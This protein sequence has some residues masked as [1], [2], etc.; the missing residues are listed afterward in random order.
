MLSRSRLTLFTVRAIGLAATAGILASCD[1]EPQ[2]VTMPGLTSSSTVVTTGKPTSPSLTILTA[3]AGALAGVMFSTQ[4][5]IEFLSSKGKVTPSA[6]GEVTASLVDAGGVILGGTTTVSASKGVATFSD[7]LIPVAGTYTVEF[8]SPDATPVTMS[9]T[10][11]TPSGCA[12]GG[13]LVDAGL[14]ISINA[15]GTIATVG[16]AGGTFTA[17]VTVSPA[18]CTWTPVSNRSWIQVQDQGVRTGNGTVTYTVDNLSHSA[19]PRTGQITLGPSSSSLS[20]FTIN[21]N[22]L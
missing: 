2:V 13:A 8:S 3:P 5:Q 22:H 4:P 10:V 12:F 14:G 17:E 7:L 6:R 1:G 21:Q 18:D 16:E 19:T 11:D 20:F 9:L 15:A